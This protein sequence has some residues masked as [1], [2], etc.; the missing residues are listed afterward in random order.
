[1][2]NPPFLFLR[3]LLFALGKWAAVAQL[4]S[5]Q[6]FKTSH[7][8]SHREKCSKQFLEIHARQFTAFQN[9]F[10]IKFNLTALKLETPHFTA[11]RLLAHIPMLLAY[12]LQFI[13][14]CALVKI[15]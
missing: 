15:W 2:H 10:S 14:K 6:R 1:M 9:C 7:T 4:C 13:L 12:K 11:A 3:M 5:N 8:L